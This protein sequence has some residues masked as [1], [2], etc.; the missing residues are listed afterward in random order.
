MNHIFAFLTRFRASIHAMWSHQRDDDTR[1][2]LES[3][4]DLATDENVRRGM[5]VDEARRQAL[6]ASGGV[7][8]AEEAVRDRRRLPLLDEFQGDLRFAARSLRRSPAFTTIVALTLALGIGAHSAIFSVV[9]GVV[10]RPLPY[11]EPER[12]LAVT[13]FVKGRAG[14]RRIRELRASDEWRFLPHVIRRRR[15]SSA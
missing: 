14:A 10:L 8:N 4:V 3:H 11:R 1:A 7:A 6:I 2:E 5:P 12:I 15:S 13:S 9:D